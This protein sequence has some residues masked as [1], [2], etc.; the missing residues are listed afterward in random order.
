KGRALNLTDLYVFREIDQLSAQMRPAGG[1]PAGDLVFV[2]NTNPRSVARQQYYFSTN[3]LY[4]FHVTR[5]TNIN[6]TPTGVKD[7]TLRFQFGAP[8]AGQRGQQV[9]TFTAIRDGVTHVGTTGPKTPRTTALN[10]SPLI[11][12]FTA[13]GHDFSVFAGLRQ[14]P[15]FFDVEQYFRVR[16]GALGFGPAVG[17]RSPGL[18]FTWGYNVNAVVVRVPRA[19]LQGSTSATTFDVWETISVGGTQLER[20]ARPAINEG[21]IITNAHLNTLNM[22]GPDCEAAALAGIPPCSTA[23]APILAEAAAFLAALGNSPAR[24]G[25]IVAAFLPDVM[26]IDTTQPSGYTAG[27]TGLNGPATLTRGRKLLDDVI[28]ATLF[29]LTNGAI[30]SDN[31]AYTD[32]IATSTP[33][34]PLL[35]AFPF[36]PAPH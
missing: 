10:Q 21:L 33:H 4:E 25:M 36:L 32:V 18:D 1:V 17:F 3:A 27:F 15:F 12:R 8:S 26:R 2:M 20:L 24:I 23:A 6:D 28:D 9:I 29:V 13:A 11:N 22:I 34:A 14:D 19:F 16:A 31:V 7:V 30:T 5:V 35:P